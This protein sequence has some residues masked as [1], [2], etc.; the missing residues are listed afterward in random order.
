[1]LQRTTLVT[2]GYL[3]REVATAETIDSEEFLHTS[4]IG[5]YDDDH[6]FYVIDR[7]KEL[8]KYK[9]FQVAPAELEG[10]LLTHEAVAEAA[11]IGMPNERA[12]EVPKAFSA[13][14][15]EFGIWRPLRLS[16]ICLLQYQK[17]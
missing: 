2:K 9:G 1:M 17:L 15:S 12:G 10:I 14:N 8:I 5:F 6:Y 13:T 3:D 11:V 7:A 16:K 4:D